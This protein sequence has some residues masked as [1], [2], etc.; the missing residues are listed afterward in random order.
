MILEY[1]YRIHHLAIWQIEKNVYLE[2]KVDQWKIKDFSDL[3]T[4]FQTDIDK[5]IRL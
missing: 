4:I 2:G 5:I 1:L 3:N